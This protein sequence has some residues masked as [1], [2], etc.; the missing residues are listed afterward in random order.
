MEN[1]DIN[2]IEF[3]ENSSVTTIYENSFD[4]S[5]VKCLNI[6]SSLIE[7]KEGWCCGMHHLEKIIISPLNGQFMLK[8]DKILLGKNVNESDE[9]DVLLFAFND[10]EE[11]NIP[12]NITKISKYALSSCKK[13]TKVEIPKDSK[14]EIIESYAFSNTKIERIFIPSNVSKIGEFAFFLCENLIEVD[15][16]ENSKLKIIEENVFDRTS[17]KEFTIPLNVT[18]ISEYAFAFCKKLEIINIPE[19]SKLQI[20]DSN[21]FYSTFLKEIYYNKLTIITPF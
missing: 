8:D 2:I 11:I 3:D 16:L 9:F 20:I 10:I 7:L 21:A 4:N 17:I 18:K 6:P 19:N 5:C 1:S 12:S 14:L 15:I 13:L